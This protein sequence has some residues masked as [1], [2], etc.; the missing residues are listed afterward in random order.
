[1]GQASHGMSVVVAPV[2]RASHGMS[3]LV[4]PVGRVSRGTCVLVYPVGRVSHWISVVVAP[5]GRASHGM[6]VLV[7][8]VGRV[9][10]GTCVLVGPVAR[11]SHGISALIAPVARVSHGIGV[12]PGSLHDEGENVAPAR[13][14]LFRHDTQPKGVRRFRREPKEDRA[15]LKRHRCTIREAGEGERTSERFTRPKWDGGTLGRARSRAMSP[16]YGEREGRTLLLVAYT[17]AAS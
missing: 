5:V 14:A 8:P 16:E 12:F 17:S 11:V 7:A 6:S 9:S 10:H 15:R 1:M 13:F 4:A 2:G 3:V